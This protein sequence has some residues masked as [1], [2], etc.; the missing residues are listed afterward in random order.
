M[1]ALDPDKTVIRRSDPSTRRSGSGCQIATN[2]YSGSGQP[3][4]GGEIPAA[5]SAFSPLVEGSVMS[6][7]RAQ[8]Y[9]GFCAYDR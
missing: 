3:G 1:R 6:P 9:A 8:V 2:S 7:E 5:Y 4:V